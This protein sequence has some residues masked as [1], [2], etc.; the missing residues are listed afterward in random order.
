MPSVNG[1]SGLH[2]TLCTL[3]N[4][5]AE[6]IVMGLSVVD[7]NSPHYSI[8]ASD[9]SLPI[10][11][12]HAVALVDGVIASAEVAEESSLTVDGTAVPLESGDLILPGLVDTH[13]HLIGP[14][15]MADRGVLDLAASAEPSGEPSTSTHP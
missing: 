14:G 1:G 5:I 7:N 3:T 2:P 12:P 13:C 4:C 10:I 6:P 8:L 11:V 9:F 15:E